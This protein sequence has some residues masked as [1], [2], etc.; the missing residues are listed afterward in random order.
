MEERMETSTKV[1]KTVLTTEIIT[2]DLIME[3]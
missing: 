3:T 1:I 2:L